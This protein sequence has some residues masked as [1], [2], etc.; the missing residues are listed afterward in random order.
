MESKEKKET[1][2]SAGF[3]RTLSA[4]GMESFLCKEKSTGKVNA[5]GQHKWFGYSCGNPNYNERLQMADMDI[6]SNVNSL[7]KNYKGFLR[8][9]LFSGKKRIFDYTDFYVFWMSDIIDDS[10]DVLLFK[11]ITNRYI[12][13]AGEVKIR[14]QFI[15]GDA[16]EIQE[17]GLDINTLKII[18]VDLQKS[19][20]A[21]KL[22]RLDTWRDRTR[23]M[24][25]IKSIEEH[26]LIVKEF[27]TENLLQTYCTN[28]L[29]SKVYSRER[30]ENYFRRCK[31]K[32]LHLWNK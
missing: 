24:Q 29:E 22:K 15:Y 19:F 2:K 12:D 6:K 28:L 4:F 8:R 14:P 17:I 9:Q 11:C 10:Q 21:G 26:S 5:D 1:K 32:S 23:S 13:E 27:K 30:L 16:E 31:K 7:M 18:L 25:N 20:K 3:N